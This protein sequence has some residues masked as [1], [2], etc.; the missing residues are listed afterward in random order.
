MMFVTSSTQGPPPQA[1]MEA[2]GQ[3]AEREFKAG[4]L[5]ETNGLMP[6][7]MATQVSLEKGELHVIDGP[8][9]ESKEVIGGYAVFEFKSNEEAVA[10]AVEFM[11]LHRQFAPG[12]EGRC[13]VRQI[14]AE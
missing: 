2:I 11:E 13:E 14:A 3:L 1:L 12:W 4:R 6:I 8:F 9:T 10:S 5:I 7:Q